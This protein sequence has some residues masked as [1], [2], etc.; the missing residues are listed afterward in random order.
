MHIDYELPVTIIDVLEAK[1]RLTGYIYKT[2]M[3]RS[4]YL[5]ECCKGEIFLKFENMQRTG[6]FKIRGAFNKLSSLTEEEKR[7]GV[8]A[9]SAGNHAQGVSLSCAILGI[10]G[11]VVMPNGAP[12]SKVAATS[13][14]SAQVVM[15]GDNFNDT[16]AKVSEI[17]EMEGRIFIPPYDDEKVIAGQGTIG[18]EILEDLYDVDN[19]IVP[20]GGGGLIAGIALAI[21]SINPTINIIGVQAENVHGM[22]ASFYKGELMAHR[23]TG[24]LADGCDVSRPG[25]ITYEIVKKLVTDIVL[26]S[27]DEIRNSMVALIQRNKVVT[28]GAGAL[29]TAALLSGKL[30]H[31]IK[32]RK[33]VSIISGGNIDLSRVSQITGSADI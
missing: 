4:N 28:E 31:Y 12:K 3:P 33:T 23:T 11:K 30:D 29:A 26:V 7:K 15:H 17:V 6:S 14:Y 32:G 16:I 2:G 25:R 20:I 1:K 21:K 27:E 22:A 9:C 18:L 10:D 8:V 13:D 19:V 5:S 24:T